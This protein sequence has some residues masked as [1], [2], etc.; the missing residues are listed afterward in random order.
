M[1]AFFINLRL[2]LKS[3]HQNDSQIDNAT[4]INANISIFTDKMNVNWSIRW[5]NEIF[6]SHF[7]L[8]DQIWLVWFWLAFFHVGDDQLK[9]NLFLQ[10]STT[11]ILQHSISCRKFY[12]AF[13]HHCYHIEIHFLHKKVWTILWKTAPVQTE[14]IWSSY[15]AA[16]KICMAEWNMIITSQ[17]CQEL[18]KL[19]EN[20]RTYMY[21]VWCGGCKF[22][23]W[24]ISLICTLYSSAL[25]GLP[26]CHVFL[27]VSYSTSFFSIARRIALWHRELQCCGLSKKCQHVVCSEGKT[28]MNIFSCSFHQL[29]QIEFTTELNT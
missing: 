19:F 16:D 29:G 23:K 14:K 3:E 11:K 20:F 17:C 22:F 4:D 9:V 2:L 28:L 6:L 24:F 25:C 8:L 18:F 7:G 5:F 10:I 15:G 1:N 21:S 26:F 13:Y 12:R 27:F